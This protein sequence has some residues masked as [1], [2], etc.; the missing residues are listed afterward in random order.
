MANPL[1]LRIDVS[2]ALPYQSPQWIALSVYLP[3]AEV[4]GAQPVAIFASPGG[5][6]TRHYYDMDFSGHVDYS[7]ALAHVRNG[8]IFVSYDHLGVGDSSGDHLREY[9]VQ[10]LATANDAAV[11]EVLGK[12][13]E[14]RLLAD[15]PALPGLKA[16][17]L[18]QSMGGNVTIAM[19]G[20]H[21]TFD[22]I[23]PLGYSALHTVLPQR[24]ESD[25]QLG[26]QGHLVQGGKPLEEIS[27]EASSQTVVD[28]VYPFH[29][30]DV[31]PDILEADM[32]G[33]YPIRQTAPRFGSF[34]VPPCAVTMMT[35]GIVK[36]EA[37]AITVPV[38]VAMGERDV[39]PEPHAEPTAYLA[40]PDVSLFIVPRMAHM[41]NFAGTRRLLWDRIE[42]WA[43][44]V[45][46]A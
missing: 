41:H 12:L 4:L 35:P 14:G 29:W 34:T 37:A 10:Q 9:T 18:G 24:D 21:A 39:C 36:E 30:E 32:G 43:R 25:R 17:G 44:R 1:E 6:Y 7:Q 11:R 42:S 40:S 26:I 28:F 19:Q 33:G 3:P 23:A 46:A 2:A 45:C 5:G 38:L 20:R 22:G 8:F 16:V 31:P 15:Y 13:R 27:V